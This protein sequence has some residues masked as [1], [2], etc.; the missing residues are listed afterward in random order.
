MKYTYEV[1]P[2]GKKFATV[3]R[4]D[5]YWFITWLSKN[6]K[7]AHAKGEEFVN[8]TR[9]SLRTYITAYGQHVNQDKSRRTYLSD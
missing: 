4:T 1:I 6:K 8:G 3:C 2:Q 9:T 7:R 5:G